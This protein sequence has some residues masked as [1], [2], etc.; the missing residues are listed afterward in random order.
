MHLEKF[1]RDFEAASLVYQEGLKRVEG[2]QQEK[3]VMKK[4]ADFHKRMKLRFERD[5][6]NELGPAGVEQVLRDAGLEQ[7][8]NN[9]KQSKKRT[10]S[11][12][13]GSEAIELMTTSKKRQLL[14]SKEIKDC[15]TLLSNY[16]QGID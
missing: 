7:S 1:K 10:L 11:Q 6:E 14:G 5:V 8:I 2:E 15:D 3:E 9:R 13:F 4:Y 16:K 12:A